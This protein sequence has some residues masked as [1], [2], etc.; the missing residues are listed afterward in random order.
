MFSD[1][2]IGRAKG[3]ARRLLPL[4][5][6]R[7]YRQHRIARIVARYEPRVVSHSYSGVPLR[8]R[9]ADPLAAGWYDKD[10]PVL[11]ELEMLRE[12]D[13]LDGALVFD[14]GAHQGVVALILAHM[15]GFDGR[16]VAVEAEPHNA[17][18]ARVNQELNGASNLEILHSAAAARC[19]TLP[20]AEGLNGHV[21]EHGSSWGKVEVPAVTVDDLAERYGAPQVVVIDVEG[22]EARVLEGCSGTLAAGGTA[23]LIEMHV[24]HGLDR[25]PS[26]VAG[27]F[28]NQYRL[29][30][31]AAEP[32]TEFVPYDSESLLVTDRFFLIALPAEAGANIA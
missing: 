18:T 32:A 11:Q 10:W 27:L 29:F 19:G 21:E 5:L 7:P 30:M 31:S 2:V 4:W 24:G 3:V 28:G 13:L 9:I 26:E 6:Y 25:S 17:K 22:F 23:F 20:F 12:R 16:V 14:L 8:I 1:A 15:V